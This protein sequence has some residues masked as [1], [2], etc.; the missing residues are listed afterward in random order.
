MKQ[1]ISE[2]QF[3]QLDKEIIEFN[4][5]E[6][7]YKNITIGKMVEFL[8]DNVNP[9]IKKNVNTDEWTIN[10]QDKADLQVNDGNGIHEVIYTSY[11]SSSNCLC[12][13]LWGAV[14]KIL[15]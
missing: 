12:D 4:F 7:E 2:E 11:I 6:V 10:F 15:K 3:N 1:H 9:S 5:S 8:N 14:L 13:L